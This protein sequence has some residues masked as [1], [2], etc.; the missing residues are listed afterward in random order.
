MLGFSAE[1]TEYREIGVSHTALLVFWDGDA[2]LAKQ[3]LQLT[4][5][6]GK[7]LYFHDRR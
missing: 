2:C 6:E 1:V 5:A 7:P 4:E 3:P